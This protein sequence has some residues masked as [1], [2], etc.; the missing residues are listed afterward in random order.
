M[1]YWEAG[2][3]VLLLVVVVYDLVQ[4]KHAILRNF[5]IIGHFR[6]LLEMIGPELR[7]YIVTSNDEER[8]FNRDQRRWVYASAKRQNNYFGFGSDN[9]MEQAEN[10]LIIKQNTF[11]LYVPHA[12]EDGYDPNYSIPCA[13]VM[14]GFRQR[15]KAFRPSSVI[16]VSAMSFGSLSGA[17]VEA[18]NRGCA[19]AGCLQN[20]G[21][22]GISRHHL[23]GGDLIW[24]IGTGYF[25]CR[26]PNGAFS[27]SRMMEA[28]EE[29]PSVRAIEIKLSQGAKAGVGGILPAAKLTPEIAA[30]RG[31]PLGRDCI[32]PTLHSAFT[33]PDGLLDFVERIAEST[34][35][36]VGIKSAV[37]EM[38]FWTELARL[39][40]T[41]GRGVDFIT[42]D[43]GEGGTGAAPLAF[44]DHVSLPF[45]LG[46]TRVYRLLAEQGLHERVVF[47][48]AGKLGF[49]DAAF[50]SFALGCDMINVARE[51]MMAIGCIQAQRCHTGHCPTGVA[52]QNRWLMRGLDPTSKSARLANYVTMLRKE[53]LMLTRACGLMHPAFVTGEHV[54]I[55]NGRFGSNTIEQVFG[56][57]HEMAVPSA[58]D[59]A[60]IA[61]IMGGPAPVAS[62]Q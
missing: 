32:S 20:T 38:G 31:I 62:R 51:S 23:H 43:G 50:L 59:L 28:I 5:P 33:G 41:T 54:E 47:I 4:R 45:K 58:E 10:Y 37:G 27:H 39:M 12:G 34:G 2:I 46:F 11:P 57:G 29:H 61:G 48:G 56:Y 19:L 30:I 24:Q 25:G 22:G 18:I 15:A 40:S 6:Y 44:S 1:W 14:G 36:P 9:E 42:I 13:K 49:P 3:V 52:T 21:E 35:L 53:L 60:A 7:Q 55:L 17:A 16:N 26:E 8:P